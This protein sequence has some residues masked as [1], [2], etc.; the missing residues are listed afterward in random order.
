MDDGKVEALERDLKELEGAFKDHVS[1]TRILKMSLERDVGDLTS[2]VKGLRSEWKSD[3]SER[4]Y[5]D[6]G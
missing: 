6:L 5:R 3:V 2:A 1:E 4:K